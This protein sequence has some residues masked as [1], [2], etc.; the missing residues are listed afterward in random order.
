MVHFILRVSKVKRSSWSSKK[1]RW[2]SKKSRW[3]SKKSRWSSKSQ[4]GPRSKK[5]NG[6][7]GE[8]PNGQMGWSNRSFGMS[9]K[10]LFHKK[11]QKIVISQKGRKSGKKAKKGPR[12][13]FFVFKREFD[14]KNRQKSQKNHTFHQ[15]SHKTRGAE[16]SSIREPKGQKGP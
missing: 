6:P 13:S 3:S 7:P 8:G 16:S 5:S 4:N 14:Q 11:T 10:S 15:K 2:S 12:W 9:K 1:S